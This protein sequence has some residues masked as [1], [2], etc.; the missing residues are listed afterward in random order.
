MKKERVD[1]IMDNIMEDSSLCVIREAL[2]Q[3]EEEAFE[4]EM[5]EQNS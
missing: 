1:E 3:Y 5:M 4:D 2:T